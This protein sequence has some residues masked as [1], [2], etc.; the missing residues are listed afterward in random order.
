MTETQS[1]VQIMLLSMI[2]IGVWRLVFLT[3]R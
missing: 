1:I 3:G 2:A